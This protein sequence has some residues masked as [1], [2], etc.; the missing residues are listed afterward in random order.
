MPIEA[1]QA[2]ADPASELF[3][4]SDHQ[5]QAALGLMHGDGRVPLLLQPPQ[6]LLQPGQPRPELVGIDDLLG[7]AVDQPVHAAAQTSELSLQPVHILAGPAVPG[8]RGTALVLRRDP[9]R[10][11]QDRHDLT[12]HRLLQLVAA[13]RA[14]AARCLAA[15]LVPVRAGATV[16]AVIGRLPPPDD[17]PR[18]LAIEGVAALPAYHEALQQPAGPAS[19]LALASAVLVQLGLDGLEHARVHDRG[20]WHRDPLVRGHRRGRAGGS[21]RQGGLPTDRAQPNR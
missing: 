12:P 2:G 3:Q 4:P 20:H 21:A 6:A 11:V 10:V 8:S 5:L 14:V 13:H 9:A 15:E 1:V 19:P 7:V 18:H 17:A 16:V